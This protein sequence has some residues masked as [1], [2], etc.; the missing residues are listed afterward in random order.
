MYSFAVEREDFFRLGSA[1]CGSRLIS[2]KTSLTSSLDTIALEFLLL[3]SFDF[4][5]LNKQKL[6][7]SE[8][9]CESR[10]DLLF[11]LDVFDCLLF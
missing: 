8:D 3:M 9:L 7:F 2:F 6:F 4:E 11:K 5:S 10:T 1:Y